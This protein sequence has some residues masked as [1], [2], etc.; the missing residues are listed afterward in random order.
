MTDTSAYQLND[1]GTHV[2][3]RH[4]VTGG[5]WQCP[6]KFL[7]YAQAKGWQPVAADEPAADPLAEELGGFDP[8]EHSVEEI[9]AHLAAYADEAPGEVARVLQL[10]AAGKNRSTVKPPAGFG[11]EDRTDV[12]VDLTGP[13]N[14]PGA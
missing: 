4:D 9:N 2:L 7:P 11:E 5:S 12:V 10:E 3:V 13:D 14:T 8:A 1:T 6:V